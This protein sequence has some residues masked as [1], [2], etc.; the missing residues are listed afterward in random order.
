V[1]GARKGMRA[2]AF[3]AFLVFPPLLTAQTDFRKANWGMSQAQ[4]M[5]TE[6]DRPNEI[7]MT[8]GETI[9]EYLG[10]KMGAFDGRVLYIFAEKKL[11]RGKFLL[12][13]SHSDKNEFI[14]DFR[15]IEPVLREQ[16]GKAD[17]D[18]A[19]WEDDST[20][21]ETKN[22]L[23]QDRATA[24]GILP[25][26]RFVGLAVLWGHLKLYTTRINGRTEIWHTL[27]GAGDRI[28]HQ[29]EYRSVS[30]RSLENRVRDKSANSQNDPVR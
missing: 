18:R 20:Q 3:V 5:A 9:V 30:L 29:L 23:D 1:K 13:A 27:W 12:D 22:Y 10:R 21:D 4:V 24:T 28:N 8:G 11:V 14:A 7:Q 6:P 25:S 15:T 17:E 16:Y 2:L 19:I 26:D